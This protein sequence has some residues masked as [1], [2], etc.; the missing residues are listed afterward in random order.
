MKDKWGQGGREERDK[1]REICKERESVNSEHKA[2]RH[3]DI[4]T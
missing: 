1:Q 4:D 2:H 3:T